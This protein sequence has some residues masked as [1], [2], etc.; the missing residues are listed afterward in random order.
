[1]PSHFTRR[2]DGKYNGGNMTR[3]EME[4]IC[5]VATEYQVQLGNQ[6]AYM[7]KNYNSEGQAAVR[8]IVLLEAAQRA[9]GELI[10]YFDWMLKA[11]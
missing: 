9:N 3:N 5:A 2:F 4:K 6:L 7:Q 1:M 10:T 8:A 11:N